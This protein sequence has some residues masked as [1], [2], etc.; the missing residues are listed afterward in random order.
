MLDTLNAAGFS[1]DS[2][3]LRM[4]LYN[5][6]EENMQASIEQRV[7]EVQEGFQ[8][9]VQSDNEQEETNSGVEF[10]GSCLEYMIKSSIRLSEFTFSKHSSIIVEFRHP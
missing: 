8:S 1:I 7:K 9:A 4:W 5:A 6:D 3:D 2:N 10:P